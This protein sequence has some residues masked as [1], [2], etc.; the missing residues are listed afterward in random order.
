MSH[1]GHP[2]LGDSLY[3]KNEDVNSLI[4][5]QALHSYKMEFTH[6]IFKNKVL[7]EAEIP[8]DIKKLII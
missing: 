4:E 5:H 6:P 2:L 1:I 8:E 3:N 7:L